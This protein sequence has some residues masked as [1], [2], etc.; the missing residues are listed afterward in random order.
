MAGQLA[1]LAGLGALRDLDL[2]H[3]GIDEILRRHP[4]AAGRHLLDRRAARPP[5]GH[6]LEALD[7]LAA[8]ARIRT[9]A[10]GVDR[11][12]QRLVRLL[13][14]GAVGHRAGGEA[15]DDVGGR[16]DRLD[17]HRRAADLGRLLDT[18]QAANGLE[19]VL[20]LVHEPS[21]FAV[22][23]GQAE[24]HGVLQGRHGVGRPGMAFAAQSVGV[25]AAD[26]EGVAIDGRVAERVGMTPGGLLGD[27]GHADALD[28]RRG[29]EEVA[30]DEGRVEADRVEDL[31][32]AIGLVGR[33]AHLGHDLEQALID[34]LDVAV[35]DLVVGEVRR[36]LVLHGDQRLEGE[37]GIDRLGAIAGQT[38]EVMHLARLTR[39]DDESDRR[40]KPLPDQIVMNR[41]RG[42]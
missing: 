37:V 32:A 23:L 25:F 30:G 29:A 31:G 40:P 6:R 16:F 41:S 36:E 18:E 33:D 10:E 38:C 19:V 21:V 11:D 5:V 22:A 26:I 8:L 42:E 14:D 7:L 15:L 20:L 2:H 35:D 39:L 17:V 3:V 13:R 9:A 34:R 28:R 4:E 27:L 1:A 12:S 24:A